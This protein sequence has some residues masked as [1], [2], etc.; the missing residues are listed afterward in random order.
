MTKKII[1][2]GCR[3]YTNY[4]EAKEYI[5]R[6][7]DPLREAYTLIFLSGGCRGADQ[8]GERFA[9]EN[10]FELQQYHADWKRFGKGAGPIRNL[11][12]VENC[13][14][15]ICFWD[16]KSRGTSSLIF[17]AKEHNKSLFIKE[18]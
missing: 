17:L 4:E 2:A 1:I 10:N 6:C 9:K 7:I 5:K 16:G 14:M 13:D 15:V 3:D 11:Q 12:M 8:I 18:I